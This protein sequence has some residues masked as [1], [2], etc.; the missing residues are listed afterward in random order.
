LGEA[1]KQIKNIMKHLVPQ[2]LGK[3]QKELNSGMSL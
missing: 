3:K 1:G 2:S